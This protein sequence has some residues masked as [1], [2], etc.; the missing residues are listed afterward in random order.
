MRAAH[1][2]LMGDGPGKADQLVPREYRGDEAHVRHVGQARLVGVVGDKDVAGA[3]AVGAVNLQHALAEMAIDGA[4][5][6]HR[7]RRDEAA[8]GIQD[9]AG[10]IPGLA[11][12][13]GIARAVEMVVHLID[14]SGDLI[15]D[16]FDGDRVDHLSPP[17][18]SR[19]R[20][21]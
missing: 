4:V 13:G 18:T 16:D 15:A 10:E 11:N 8:A 2:G 5:E 3:D 7:R 1:I 14:Q 19:I 9:D 17:S 12:D 6:E 21:P 20:L